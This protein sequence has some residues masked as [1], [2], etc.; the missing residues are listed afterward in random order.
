MDAALIK[1]KRI[2]F[3]DHLM[4]HP[5][6]LRHIKVHEIGI[7]I[8]PSLLEFTSG[9]S[10]FQPSS[11]IFANGFSVV[12]TAPFAS[13]CN[14][15]SLTYEYYL[16]L[17]ELAPDLSGLALVKQLILNSIE[18]NSMT[19]CQR[20]KTLLVWHKYWDNWIKDIIKEH[21]LM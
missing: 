6:V 16:A 13:Y 2:S 12:L 4:S 7:E 3:V 21:K 17:L 8:T 5:E 14:F 9:T 15:T 1:F 18:H 11:I 10:G 20:H 19:P